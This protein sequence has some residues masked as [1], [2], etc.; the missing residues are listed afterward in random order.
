MSGFAFLDLLGTLGRH[1][2]QAM[3]Y[4][5][6]TRRVLRVAPGV[7]ERAA[8]LAL[9]AVPELEHAE[10]WVEDDHL[11]FDL[12]TREG[13]RVRLR[14][15]P[16]DV[17]IAGGEFSFVARM[18]GGLQVGHDQPLVAAVVTL[19]DGIFR[20]SEQQARTIPGLEL[21]GEELIYR[22]SFAPAGTEA[23]LVP[24]V[25]FAQGVGLPTRFPVAIRDGWLELALKR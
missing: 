16:Q 5:D 18:P 12:R 2:D 15:E 11:V 23:W 21:D 14:I 7:V 22:R 13:A 20:L 17:T 8:G 25:Q 9:G 10:A 24:L 6:P 3:V 4:V 1:L 19:I